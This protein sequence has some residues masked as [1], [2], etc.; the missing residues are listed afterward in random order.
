[1]ESLRTHAE[2]KEE[3][4]E[5]LSMQVEATRQ[6]LDDAEKLSAL[7]PE[8]AI[9]EIANVQSSLY[10]TFP[11]STLEAYKELRKLRERLTI[12]EQQDESDELSIDLSDD[13]N[14]MLDPEAINAIEEALATREKIQGDIRELESEGRV[15]YVSVVTEGLE[16]LKQK[17]HVQEVFNAQNESI[18]EKQTD[19]SKEDVVRTESD[20]FSTIFV[21]K[22]DAWQKAGRNLKN[23]GYFKSGTNCIFIN[24]STDSSEDDW[25]RTVR[26]ERTHNTLDGIV[27][28]TP[29]DPSVRLRSG[30]KRLERL[31]SQKIPESI[32]EYEAD[33]LMS[34]HSLRRIIDSVHN[35]L[36]AYFESDGDNTLNTIG[37]EEMKESLKGALSGID[38]SR[39]ELL[40]RL[41]SLSTAGKQLREAVVL[42]RDL[43]KV[44]KEVGLTEKA[45]EYSDTYK[46]L[47]ET[48]DNLIL[49]SRSNYVLAE[50]LG[51]EALADRRA[52][53]Y[54]LKPSQYRHIATYLT[55][56]YT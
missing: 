21:I 43:P 27:T 33:K 22:D 35:E 37:S 54:V 40:L 24:E 36:L 6:L 44:L 30:I 17:A 56:K 51:P 9:R 8:V 45:Q 39:S 28:H 50:Q 20:A 41:G 31:H 52:L 5:T 2:R 47:I 55:S 25:E 32:L 48:F 53:L 10:S 38:S 49:E 42:L 34:P 19:F 1:M 7:P 3:I 29:V 4:I 46:K 12:L 13:N 16:A 14:D 18:S 15:Q 11:E 23:F 26:H